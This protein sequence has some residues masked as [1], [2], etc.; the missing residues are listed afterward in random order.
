MTL[1]RFLATL[2]CIA[3]AWSSVI[4]TNIGVNDVYTGSYT[5]YGGAFVAAQFKT[6][7]IGPLDTV[8]MQLE[9]N[10]FGLPPELVVS[11]RGPATDPNGPII[12]SWV[13][14]PSE[15]PA[16]PGRIEM[17]Q[18]SLHPV[19]TPGSTYWLRAESEGPFPFE[20]YGWA[21]N[22]TGDP[23]PAA[24]SLNTGGSWAAAGPNPAFEVTTVP[25]AIPE[26]ESQVLLTLG[27]LLVSLRRACKEA[28]WIWKKQRSRAGLTSLERRA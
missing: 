11:L 27:A 25:T 22:V 17:L 15:I 20:S 6:T 3:P 26:P 10:G 2:V 1:T 9:R 24:V 7:G 23:G 18:S 21:Q 4:Y 13:L 19:L 5:V 14:A 8:S 16:P 12:E 28:S